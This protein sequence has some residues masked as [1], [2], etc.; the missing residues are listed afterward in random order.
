MTVWLLTQHNTDDVRLPRF[1]MR[2]QIEVNICE[3]ITIRT[4]LDPDA[5]T[6]YKLGSVQNYFL[7]TKT[8]EQRTNQN[9]EGLTGDRRH[10]KNPQRHEGTQSKTPRNRHIGGS[11]WRWNKR[12]TT[13]NENVSGN[14]RG[15]NLQSKTGS[16]RILIDD[17]SVTV[18]GRDI[19]QVVVAESI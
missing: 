10:R 17:V 12:L 11:T 3:L 4:Q 1:E 16:S 8:E 9:S 2:G 14:R 19:S 7:N 5:D 13:R 18:T 6:N 15:E